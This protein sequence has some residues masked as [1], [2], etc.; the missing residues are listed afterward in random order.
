MLSGPAILRISVLLILAGILAALVQFLLPSSSPAPDPAPVAEA[1]AASTPAEPAAPPPVS[2]PAPQPAA[3]PPSPAAPRPLQQMPSDALAVP[4]EP[5]PAQQQGEAEI[6]RAEDSAGPRAIAI[7]DLNTAS[8]ADLN[9]LRGGGAI[10]RAIVA[11]RPYTSVE[12]LLSKRVLSRAVY[13]KIKDQVT[14]R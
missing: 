10:G 8:A 13:D 6:D 12:Q 5:A 1:P 2:E 7:L 11:K 14:V 3:P 9:K 4:S